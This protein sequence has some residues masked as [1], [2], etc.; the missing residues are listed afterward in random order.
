MKFN[1]TVLYKDYLSNSLFLY[2]FYKYL[3]PIFGNDKIYELFHNFIFSLVPFSVITY[4]FLLVNES[5]IED[6]FQSHCLYIGNFIGYSLHNASKLCC[7]TQSESLVI[8]ISLFCCC[9]CFCCY[10][11]CNLSDGVV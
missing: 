5:Q 8:T 10:F 3:R 4:L 2:M 1:R 7:F 6:G 11:C 9:S